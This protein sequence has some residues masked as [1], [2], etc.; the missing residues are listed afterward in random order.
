MDHAPSVEPSVNDPCR[1]LGEWLEHARAHAGQPNWNVIMLATVDERGRP[2]V[3]PVLNKHYDP[4]TGGITFFTNY[5]S[6]KAREMDAHPDVSIVMH[7]DHLDRQV[8]MEGRVSRTSDEVSDEYFSSRRRESQLGAWAS[9]QSEPL[10]SYETLMKRVIQKGI[11]FADEPVP[12]PPDWGGYELI[13]GAIEFWIG[14]ESRVHQRVRFKRS[15][16]GTTWSG[17]WLNP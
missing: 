10:D 7:W 5:A 11:E 14:H 9:R 2:S 1:L 6:R 17:T 13:P 3:R 15:D 8:R 4:A 16:D 12:R